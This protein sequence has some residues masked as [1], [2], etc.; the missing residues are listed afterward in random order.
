M[1]ISGTH[2]EVVEHSERRCRCAL[3]HSTLYYILK[4]N[5]KRYLPMIHMPAVT[6]M[7]GGRA[8]KG[9]PVAQST[10]HIDNSL[11]VNQAANIICGS[12]VTAFFTTILLEA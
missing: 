11:V 7:F 8:A 1:S 10:T 2:A 4:W 5:L 12:Y 6:V 9:L 3:I